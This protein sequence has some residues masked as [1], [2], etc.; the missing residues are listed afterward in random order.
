MRTTILFVFTA[1]LLS[2]Q[3][4][5]QS[6]RW[7]SLEGP[8]GGNVIKIDVSP[9]GDIYVATT[10]E[11]YGRRG[12]DRRFN[13]INPNNWRTHSMAVDSSGIFYAIFDGGLRISTDIGKSWE[14]V[15]TP[16]N[17]ASG[18]V[19]V[20]M[21]NALTVAR[22]RYIARRIN[23]NWLFDTMPQVVS[24][25]I[26]HG[27]T[28][29]AIGSDK[30]YAKIGGLWMIVSEGIES[31]P[32]SI[33]SSPHGLLIGTTLNGVYLSWKLSAPVVSISENL[34]DWL[35]DQVYYADD[36]V[37]V[38]TGNNLYVTSD[39]G[40]TW[41]SGNDRLRAL[42]VNSL[43]YS[44]GNWYAGTSREAL[45]SSSD[46][47]ASWRAI[48]VGIV[49]ST[50]GAIAE[51][52]NEIWTSVD[53]NSINS[54]NAV[55][56]EWTSRQDGM[57]RGSTITR[58]VVLRDS[59]YALEE[60]SGP[61]KWQPDSNRWTKMPIELSISSTYSDL[62][63]IDDTTLIAISEYPY[64]FSTTTW[65]WR[66]LPLGLYPL[67]DIDHIGSDI[68]I[69]S[70]SG[71]FVSS[72]RGESWELLHYARATRILAVD[73]VLFLRAS[74]GQFRSYD[75]GKSWQPFTLDGDLYS[76][77][78][79][80]YVS[81][82]TLSE[83]TDFGESFQQT[84]SLPVTADVIYITT[85]D[86]RYAGIEQSGLFR[87]DPLGSVSPVDTDATIEVYPSPASERIFLHEIRKELKIRVLDLS[88]RVIFSGEI[89]EQGL[90]IKDWSPGLY[91]LHDATSGLHIG[92]FL[93]A[94]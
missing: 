46:R 39:N 29:V 3:V 1:L 80:L 28:L 51:Y 70:D 9:E 77:N 56:E 25:V 55:T 48:N 45:F 66:R 68:F 43:A 15:E 31:R 73:S 91:I 69:A 12:T 85:D 54:Y 81:K 78:N 88:G 4:L 84:T 7:K 21:G 18:Y 33:E 41:I 11:L 2:S 20:T 14:T 6:G 72:N 94:R 47:G 62:M 75:R 22:G 93:V 38:A 60:R 17:V 19:G 63:A 92:R 74:D 40:A 90:V 87:F 79:K 61:Y 82:N 44:N 5:A 36:R 49:E 50:V 86:Q 37:A 23:A 30:V 53:I 65:S 42:P 52:Q 67:H 10:L 24:K 58:F 8:D 76:F 83:S 35:I 57:R 59:L 89:G 71:L 16:L 13:K 26:S 32:T 34:P 64:R 27:D